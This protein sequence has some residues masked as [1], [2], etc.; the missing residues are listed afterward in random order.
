VAPLP[1]ES[2]QAL[3]ELPPVF[4][5]KALLEHASFLAAPEREGRG[6]GSRGGEVAASYVAERFKALGLQPGGD[7][8]GFLQRFRLEKG[9]DGAPVETANVI[10]ILPGNKPERQGQSV[11]VSAH[12]D[13]LGRG[14]PDVRQG[15]AGKVHP[16]ADDNASGVA[17]LLE[18]AKAFAAA[19]K[20]PRSIVFV[21]F[22]AEEA[23]RLGSIHYVEKTSP[24]P[25]TVI[26]V[27]NLDTV[28][29]LGDQK[30]SVLGTGT[31]TEWPH[32][33]RGIGFVTGLESRM[34]PEPL[35]SSDQRSFVDRGIPAVQLFTQPHADYHRP[36]DTADKLDVAGLVKVATVA[37]EAVQYLAERPQPL[38]VTIARTEPAPAAPPAAP[39]GVEAPGRRVTLGTLP[40]FAFPG[41]GVRVASVTPGSA[42]EK[43]GIQEGDVVLRLAGR[44]VANL[45]GYS[46]ILR[47]LQ[48][49]RA[50]EVV[51]SRGGTS[52]T[53]SAT[54]VAR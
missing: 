2:R 40:D 32:I 14:W 52:V 12:Y 53:L 23:G 6:P 29:R 35:P 13:H 8:G 17:V 43:A 21:A 20:P 4:A 5:Q 39:A 27:I 10:G 25:A 38:T 31:A 9:P 28:G 44:D 19:G 46:D 37:R 1:A 33:F 50:V 22:G 54:P 47:T 26:G 18:L 36:S 51:V 49:G 30:L 11:V 34:I 3:A 7:G 41:P 15:E 45:Q 42:A 48:A 16:G 24:T